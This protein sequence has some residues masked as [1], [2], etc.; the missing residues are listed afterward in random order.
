VSTTT[1]GNDGGI[2]FGTGLRLA[3]AAAMLYLRYASPL[4]AYN[5]MQLMNL[6]GMSMLNNPM[7][8]Q[9]QGAGVVGTGRGLDRTAGAAMYVMDAMA[10]GASSGIGGGPS[11]DASLAEALEGA[12]KKTREGLPR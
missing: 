1:E 6:G 4:A 8:M 7:L 2:G 3:R 9:M 11:F 10:A 5:S 12:A